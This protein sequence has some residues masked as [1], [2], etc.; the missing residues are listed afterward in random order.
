MGSLFCKSKRSRKPN[1]NLP[2]DFDPKKIQLSDEN[3]ISYAKNN[4]RKIVSGLKLP[5]GNL[6]PE[7]EDSEEWVFIGTNVILT[8]VVN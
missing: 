6:V 3:D 2:F 8:K 1:F 5:S 7:G 4:Q